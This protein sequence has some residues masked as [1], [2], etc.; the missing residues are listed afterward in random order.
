M[1]RNRLASFFCD[2]RKAFD[3]VWHKG[4]IFKLKQYGITDNILKWISSYLISR[5]QKVFVGSTFSE[6]RTINAGVP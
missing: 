4:L 2:I 3:R 5:K 6:E 1:T